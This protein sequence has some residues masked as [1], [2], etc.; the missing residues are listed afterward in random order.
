MLEAV[1]AM[2]LFELARIKARASTRSRGTVQYAGIR[3]E[4]QR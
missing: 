4:S 1:M 2:P 3:P